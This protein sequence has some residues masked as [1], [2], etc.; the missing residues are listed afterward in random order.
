MRVL[1]RFLRR[2]PAGAL[3]QKDRSWDGEEVTL[4]RATDQ[5]VQLKDRRVA[6]AHAR[7]ILRNGR[8]VLIS[9]VPGGVLVNGTLQREARLNAGDA[10]TI[11]SNLLRILEPRDGCDLAFSFEL[12]AEARVDE[13]A[14]SL[15]RL[16]LADLELGRRRWSWALFLGVLAVA[17]VIPAAGVRS[18]ALQASLRSSLLPDDGSWSPGPVSR[19]HETVGTR[20]EACHAQPFRRVQNGACLECHAGNVHEHIGVAAVTDRRVLAAKRSVAALTEVRCASC[21]QEHEEPATLVRDDPAVC[22]SCH[23]DLLA[24]APWTRTDPRVTDFAAGH[25]DFRRPEEDRSGLKFPHALHLAEEGIRSPDGDTVLGCNDCHVPE[26]DGARFRPLRMERDCGGCHL[27]DFDPADPK[28]VVPHGD[29]AAVS[30]FLVD[31]YSRRYLENFTDPLAARA[32]ARR[33]APRPTAA[34]R[35]RLLGVARDRAGRVLRDLF[36][37][38]SCAQCHE[39]ARE[40]GTTER[41][42]VAPV[43]LRSAWLPGARFSHAAHSTAL[44]RCSTCHEAVASKD[45]TDVLL[46]GID[47]CRDCHAGGDARA[48]PPDHITSTC[49]LCHGFHDAQNPLWRVK[50]GVP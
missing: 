43:K 20:C 9:R 6:L 3:E 29:A 41:W 12:D 13:V 42:T 18:P 1:I 17:L 23:R 5:V 28:R 8:P 21:H 27:L 24:V 50:A 14:A 7:I 4:G 47:T 36:E 34:D 32:V 30:D 37:R 45:S 26:P 35:E 16:R 46:P 48:T 19:V 11:G 15:P 39:V 2:G 40:S 25:P 49:T 10:V 31:Y 38:R 44:T 22:T 33:P